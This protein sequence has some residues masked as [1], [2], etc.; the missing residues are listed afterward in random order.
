MSFGLA[1]PSSAR[2]TRI[3]PTPLSATIQAQATYVAASGYY[4]RN[5]AEARKINVDIA[6]TSGEDLQALIGKLYAT[7]ADVVAKARAAIA[8]KP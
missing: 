7:P 4:V 6:P 3:R 5:A 8:F 1:A 2:I